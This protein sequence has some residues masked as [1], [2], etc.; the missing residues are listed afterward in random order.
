MQQEREAKRKALYE[1]KLIPKGQPY[2]FFP[3][4]EGIR[5]VRENFFAFHGELALNYKVVSD[6]FTETEKCGLREVDI[7]HFLEPYNA[8]TKNSTYKELI[9]MG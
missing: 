6:T 4:D 7:W 5:K 8:V 3:T 1:K 9:K 2:N